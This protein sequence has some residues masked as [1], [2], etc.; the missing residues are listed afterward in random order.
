M[1]DLKTGM[2]G[3]IVS[4]D[5]GTS[6]FR[7]RL[8]GPVDGDVICER[9]TQE[10]ISVLDQSREALGISQEDRASYLFRYL[11]GQLE[12]LSEASGQ[13]VGNLPVVISGM[14]SSGLGIRQL[15][16]APVPFRLD[17]R[18]AV[19]ARIEGMLTSGG[20]VY[21]LSGVS[22]GNDMLR[23]EEVELIG[24]SRLLPALGRDEQDSV[25][26]LPG[27][28]SKHVRMSGGCLTAI[29][30][31]L[32]GEIFSLLGRHGV[33][34][35]S[36]REGMGFEEG[37]DAFLE[38]V[39]A[40]GDIPLLRALFGIRARQ[41]LQDVDPALNHHYLSGLLIGHELRCLPGEGVTTYLCAGTGLEGPYRAA[42]EALY[43]DRPAIHVPSEL[44]ARA[45]AVAHG[46]L[47]QQLFRG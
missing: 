35:N 38:G 5:W 12:A 45:C 42:L 20:V 26:V 31:Y 47:F 28:H 17:G 46:H 22:S 37:R 29:D 24:V 1:R 10:G 16:Y 19:W 21:L 44:M 13:V 7:L 43:P 32:T 23:G 8:V 9:S 39:M 15:P 18:D 33:L 25:V 41:V 11:D 4:C 14:A 27:T 34:R 6:T 40:S 36:L 3:R 30:T 2:R